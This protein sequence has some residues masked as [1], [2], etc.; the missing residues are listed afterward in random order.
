MHCGG[1]F[2]LYKISFGCCIETCRCLESTFFVFMNACN[3]I[4][5]EKYAI[6]ILIGCMFC[7]VYMWGVQ[8][9]NIVFCGRSPTDKTGISPQMTPPQPCN[10]NSAAH[11]FTI[12][13]NCVFSLVGLLSRGKLARGRQESV[14]YLFKRVM[15]DNVGLMAT[16]SALTTLTP[17]SV[18]M[19]PIHGLLCKAGFHYYYYCTG[20]FRSSKTFVPWKNCKRKY[21]LCRGKSTCLAWFFFFLLCI[22]SLPWMQFEGICL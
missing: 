13:T 6:I 17:F 22:L 11:L 16:K 7:F 10:I 14:M 5:L 4:F 8:F 20:T 21:D 12:R 19:S 2:G 9:N 18:V 1:L 3:V 15:E